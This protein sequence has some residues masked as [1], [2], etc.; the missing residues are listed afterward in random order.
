[1]SNTNKTVAG[2][3]NVERHI[4]SG[5]D[6]T[7]RGQAKICHDLKVEGWLEAKNI[8]GP[9]KGL[10]GS[11][12]QLEERYPHP[13]DGWW[14]MV[15]ESVPAPIYRADGGA[16]VATGEEGGTPSIDVS[17]FLQAAIEAVGGATA[18]F[19]DIVDDGEIRRS[20]RTKAGGRIVYVASK[21]VFSYQIDGVLYSDWLVEDV[22]SA[23]MYMDDTRT[24]MQA[25]KLYICGGTCYMSS[26]DVGLLQLARYSDIEALL[27][28]LQGTSPESSAETDPFL[29]LGTFTGEDV[30][31]QVA[32]TLNGLV[33]T[34]EA[35]THRRAGLCRLSV[36]GARVEVVNFPLDY[37][38]QSQV[39][40]MT[41]CVAS[42]DGVT[43]ARGD[44]Q[45][46]VRSHTSSGGWTR[47]Q[48]AVQGRTDF[49]G[50]NA[51]ADAEDYASAGNAACDVRSW[52]VTAPHGGR[53]VVVGR[54]WQLS[55]AMGH[56]L[57]QVLLTHHEPGEDGSFGAHTDGK[58]HM[59]KR[60]Y[61]LLQGS[62][63]CAPIG[64]WTEWTDLLAKP[65]VVTRTKDGFA[66][67]EMFT[68]MLQ[69]DVYIYSDVAPDGEDHIT[70]LG[71]KLTSWC[72]EASGVPLLRT[73]ETNNG[74]TNYRQGLALMFR[75]N[76]GTEKFTFCVEASDKNASVRRL[77]LL[78]HLYG[79]SGWA[80]ADGVELP[81]ELEQ[82]IEE[83]AAMANEAQTGVTEGDPQAGF[84][85]FVD[86][87][88]I[89]YGSPRNWSRIVFVRDQKRFAAQQQLE[90][91]SSWGTKDDDTTHA[92]PMAYG[93]RGKT[94]LLTTTG[95]LYVRLA[96]GSLEKVC[97]TEDLA[98]RV[99]ELEE[100]M[101]PV[102]SVL[103]ANKTLLE[104][105][106]SEQDVIM[107]WSVK[108]KGAA[109][110]VTSLVVTKTEGSGASTQVY[111]G[112]DNPGSQEIKVNFYGATSFALTADVGGNS[113][114]ASA[115]VQMVLPVYA[116]FAAAASDV[117][118][119]SLVKQSVRTSA[120]G[121]Y[122]LT[123]S[124][125]GNYLWLC[126]PSTMTVKRVTLNGFDVPM[127]A[128]EDGETTLGAYK[129]YRSSNQLAAQDFAFIVS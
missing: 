93:K 79:D 34:E 92:A 107:S 63:D 113:Y 54:L 84:D 94:H 39:Q 16:W 48:A 11:V 125:T 80:F 128:A 25:D 89:Q 37:A 70:Q 108:R 59:W 66:S 7:V 71:A 42:A 64:E 101:W 20:T 76:G 102:E 38:A 22:P 8:K 14:A 121:T 119:T 33:V 97:K 1:M 40:V 13:Q 73:Y 87:A 50:V 61:G 10:F 124:Q 17:E 24:L 46:L 56:Q 118:I 67:S 123:N 15:G 9:A 95:E 57:T 65:T 31:E 21:K 129:C 23:D 90:Y 52:A 78:H 106:G 127:E 55:D 120:A 19:D 110:D 35:E 77:L 32:E 28:R 81:F 98:S 103:K 43:L 49:A 112:T 126:V 83:V 53:E 3:L 18:R 44:W 105:T 51:I 2:D 68:R 26:P 88:T 45:Q 4:T 62:S 5:G 72:D 69:K 115:R 116:G 117:D 74:G 30:W 104:Y 60:S 86:S 6:L 29:S 85:G 111:S 58:V 47:W 91:Y 114:K 109:V 27:S 12:T 41:G 36:D 122:T 82:Q 96:D 99:E 100:T 75:S